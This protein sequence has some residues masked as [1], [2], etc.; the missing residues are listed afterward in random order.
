MHTTG[1]RL[2]HDLPPASIQGQL[3]A[4]GPI[5]VLA[6]QH[7]SHLGQQHIREIDTSTGHGSKESPL[8][9]RRLL[10]VIANQ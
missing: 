1:L 5:Q 6:P 3:V 4:G 10:G 9:D 2:H 7:Q 8:C